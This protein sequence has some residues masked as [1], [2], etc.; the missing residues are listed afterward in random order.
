MG[1]VLNPLGGFFE[2]ALLNSSI[3][4]QL[5]RIMGSATVTT[6][7][8][9][10]DFILRKAFSEPSPIAIFKISLLLSGKFILSK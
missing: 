3:I 7:C 9:K 4:C 2:N 10:S 6:C 8:D 5:W 1:F